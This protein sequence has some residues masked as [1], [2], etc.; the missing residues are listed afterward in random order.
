MAAASELAGIFFMRWDCAVLACS[1][2][3]STD[4]LDDRLKMEILMSSDWRWKNV[5]LSKN[6]FTKDQLFVHK[7]K[8]NESNQGKMNKRYFNFNQKEK[9][10]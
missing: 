7:V 10:I 2:W 9:Y 5:V 4:A 1:T 3:A 8:H 6:S